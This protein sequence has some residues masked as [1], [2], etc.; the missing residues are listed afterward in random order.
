MRGGA[1]QPARAITR[2][3]VFDVKAS[4]HAWV[5]GVVGTDLRGS[6]ALF[7]WRE[8]LEEGLEVGRRVVLTKE[9][10]HGLVVVAGLA[11][12]I[13]NLVQLAQEGRGDAKVGARGLSAQGQLL[14][15]WEANGR[16]DEVD[17]FGDSGGQRVRPRPQA[18]DVEVGAVLVCEA[19]V[20]CLQQLLGE[21][22]S[23]G[24]REEVCVTGRQG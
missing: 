16:A 18:H 12:G 5:R 11:G 2:T 22:D 19:V 13:A 9:L 24:D 21:A 4:L 10:S 15:S 3:H 23:G 7:G 14:H 6:F 20:L 17:G 1:W 8:L